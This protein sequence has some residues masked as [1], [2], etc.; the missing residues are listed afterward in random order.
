MD[1]LP[2]IGDGVWYH[3]SLKDC[4]GPYTV[5]YINPEGRFDLRSSEEWLQNARPESVE[6]LVRASHDFLR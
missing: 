2:Q 3:G 6:L 1:D 4:H 5:T